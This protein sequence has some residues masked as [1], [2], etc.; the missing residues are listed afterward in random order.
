MSIKKGFV[1]GMKGYWNIRESINLL[2]ITSGILSAN[3]F[4]APTRK[5]LITKS[6]DG[7]CKAGQKNQKVSDN[8]TRPRQLC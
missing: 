8:D 3:A 7:G 6:G 2:L 5:L 1:P 4:Y